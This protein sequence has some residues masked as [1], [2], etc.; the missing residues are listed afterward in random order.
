MGEI[1]AFMLGLKQDNLGRS[2]SDLQSYNYFWLE[3]D[4]KFIQVLF[5][6]DQGHKFNRHAPLVTDEDIAEFASNQNAREAHLVS[7]D[8]ML[9]YYGFVREGAQVRAREEL[10]LARH[11]WPKPK[12]HN[13]LRITRILRS[14]YL[15]GNQETAHSFYHALVSAAKQFDTIDDVVLG[16][17]SSAIELTE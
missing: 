10:T 6:I 5:P 17:W 7:L 13:Q 3:H 14:L 1:A 2:I 15:L 11:E 8:M 16:H 12:N 9:D 4:H